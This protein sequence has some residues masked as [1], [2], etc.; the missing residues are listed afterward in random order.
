MKKHCYKHL[1]KFKIDC[2]TANFI[3]TAHLLRQ[4]L[5]LTD[6]VA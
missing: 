2:F 4:P 3:F 5:S 1:K 6:F